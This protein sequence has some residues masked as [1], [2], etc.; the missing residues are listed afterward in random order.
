MSFGLGSLN[1]GQFVEAL[2]INQSIVSL[3]L[4]E[5]E[6][7]DEGAKAMAHAL[8]INC[9]LLKNVKLGRNNIEMNGI[10]AIGN[11][12]QHNQ[13]LEILDIQRNPLHGGEHI[14]EGVHSM[15]FKVRA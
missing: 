3:N 4:T 8:K 5:N 10:T 9:S 1:I 2:S 14:T 11:A 12:L 6:L 13:M 7:G 15:Q